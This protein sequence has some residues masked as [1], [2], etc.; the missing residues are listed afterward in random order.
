MLENINCN[1][2]TSRL[3]LKW[4][5]N[6]VKDWG[7]FDSKKSTPL[8]LTPSRT[9][10]VLIGRNP[11][12]WK[13]C[14]KDVVD[15]GSCWSVIYRSSGGGIPDGWRERNA[16]FHSLQNKLDYT[17]TFFLCSGKSVQSDNGMWANIEI[18]VN[19]AWWWST[20]RS[21]S[22]IIIMLYLVIRLPL[23][24]VSLV[25]RLINNQSVN[26]VQA[27]E[28]TFSY[29]SFPPIKCLRPVW[30]LSIYYRLPRCHS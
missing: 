30:I 1:R 18:G 26:E 23:Q 4:E 13:K 15:I 28:A 10:A 11:H 29:P 24:L 7:W 8:D 16:V 5:F 2:T 27:V 3:S 14:Q 6:T 17:D 25:M 22:A 9:K 19:P 12:W 20:E 21:G